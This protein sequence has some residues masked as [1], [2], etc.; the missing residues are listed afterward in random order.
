MQLEQI[1]T[2]P[3]S[4]VDRSVSLERLAQHMRENDVGVLPV[5]EEGKVSGMVTDRDVVVR[6]LA[7]GLDV[8]TATVADVMTN[9][10]VCNYAD[11]EVEQALQAMRE[12]QVRRVVVIDR[13]HRPLGIVSLGDVATRADVTRETQRVLQG[14]SSGPLQSPSGE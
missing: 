3:L 13:D 4:M 1:M 12:R 5:V 8:K 2:S 7:R 14:V 10:V 11:E 6:G 9:K